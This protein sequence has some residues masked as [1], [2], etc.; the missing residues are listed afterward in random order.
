[1]TTFAVRNETVKA[2][3]EAFEVGGRDAAKQALRADMPDIND[4]DIED[5]VRMVLLAPHAL[6]ENKVSQKP[7]KS[8]KC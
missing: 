5:L 8:T 7:R 2:A 4:S 3:L 6:K 1:M